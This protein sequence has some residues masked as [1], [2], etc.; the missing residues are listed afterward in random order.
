MPAFQAARYLVTNREYLAF[1]EAGG[2]ADDSVWD[3]E[4]LGW[5]R[6]VRAEQPTF[7]VPD[8][9]NGSCAC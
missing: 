8:V 6:Y 2:Y 3:E 1:V 9:D 4:G 7:W 5:K